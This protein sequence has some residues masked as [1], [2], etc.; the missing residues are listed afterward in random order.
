MKILAIKI[1]DKVINNIN[2]EEILNWISKERLIKIKKYLQKS[3]AIKSAIG[4]LLIKFY[5][6]KYKGMDINKDIE[7]AY[8]TYGKPYLKD[9]PIMSH[10]QENG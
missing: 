1:E 8:N 2:K 10:T 7:F 5:L 4:E 6:Y 9:Y 3:D